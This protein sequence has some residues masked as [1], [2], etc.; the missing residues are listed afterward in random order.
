MKCLILMTYYNRPKLVRNALKSLLESNKHFTNWQL[1]FCD[2]GSKIPGEPIVRDVLKDHLDKVFFINT[3]NSIE[4][5]S[6]YGIC[7]GQHANEAIQKT[8]AD[9]VVLFSCDDEL[10]PTYLRDLDKFL[11]DNPGVLHG[12]SH[13]YIFNPIKQLSQDVSNAIGHYNQYRDPMNCFGKMDASQVFFRTSCCKEH[14][15]WFKE[16]TDDGSDRPWVRNTDAEF[17]QALY[18]KCGPAYFSGLVGQYKGIHDYQFVWYKNTDREG[19]FS[20]HQMIT[21]LVGEVF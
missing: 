1:G 2:D 10:A 7:L 8:D 19:F 4:H 15:A 5:K 20:Y 9:F 14:G 11:M 13:V 12:Y 17:F 21:E 3:N 6:K 16:T 18:D